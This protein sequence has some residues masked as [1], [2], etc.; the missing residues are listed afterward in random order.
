MADDTTMG[1]LAGAGSLGVNLK[2]VGTHIGTADLVAEGTTI[3]SL[4]GAVAQT[5]E[6]S[7][8]PGPRP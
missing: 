4:A 6:D 8:A 3:G 5:W 7:K 1:P 2:S